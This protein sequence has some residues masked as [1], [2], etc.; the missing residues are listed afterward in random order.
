MTAEITAAVSAALVLDAS[1]EA[2]RVNT[3]KA[4]D[5]ELVFASGNI[6]RLLWGEVEIIPEAT[7]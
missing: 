1:T 7:K 2:R 3:L 5:I 6:V 4:Y